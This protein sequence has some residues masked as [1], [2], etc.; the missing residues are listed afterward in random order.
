MSDRLE[1]ALRALRE[2]EDGVHPRADQTLARIL[3]DARVVPTQRAKRLR[4]W[5]LVA[6][7][8]AVSSAAAARTGRV[9]EAV[10]ALVSSEPPRT[11]ANGVPARRASAQA[12]APRAPDAPPEDGVAS[13]PSTAPLPEPALGAPEP[14]VRAE[15]PSPP[16]E[17]SRLAAALRGPAS[18]PAR[19]P[20]ADVHGPPSASMPSAA[21][22][23]AASTP[24]AASA[25]SAPS[26]PAPAEAASL[27]RV[28]PDDDAY[29][30]AHRLHFQGA[31]PSAALVAWDQYL[32]A[33]PQGRFV[34]EA[35]YNRAIDLLKLQR[36]AE[37]REALRP[38]ASSAYGDYHRDDARAILR[39]IP[40]R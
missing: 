20:A 14:P 33:F 36:Y 38:F 5:W 10:F 8:L 2:T 30:R 15:G 24:S 4:L 31:D 11:P 23:P 6:A 16:Q 9:R 34:P 21:A 40:E 32:R 1:S 28:S 13:S 39:S 17:P 3:D 35:R 22:S 25:P 29:A 7:A 27:P 26:V 19:P 18:R 37:A 12:P